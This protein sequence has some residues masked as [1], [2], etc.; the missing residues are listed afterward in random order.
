MRKPPPSAGDAP[1]TVLALL[2]LVFV[3]AASLSDGKLLPGFLTGETAQATIRWETDDETLRTG[4]ILFTPSDGNICEQRLIDN[5]T[6]RI[7]PNGFVLC[8]EAVSWHA[9]QRERLTTQSRIEAIRD[10]FSPRR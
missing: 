9:G 6:W 3:I 2:L 5:H 8:D 1:R 7:H 10:G 4:S